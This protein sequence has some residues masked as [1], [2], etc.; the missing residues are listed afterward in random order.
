MIVNGRRVE[1]EQA[2]QPDKP[3]PPPP[4][5]NLPDRVPPGNGENEQVDGGDNAEPSELDKAWQ[6]LRSRESYQA[7]A[8]GAV[9][10]GGAGVLATRSI[11]G[12]AI[13]TALGAGAGYLLMEHVIMGDKPPEAKDQPGGEAPPSVQV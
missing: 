6:Q 4:D 5:A 2:T 1:I 10:G 7:A 13:G 12:W 3:P 11:L 8:V 9:V